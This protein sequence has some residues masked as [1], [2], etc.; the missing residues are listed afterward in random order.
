MKTE[1]SDSEVV[2]QGIYQELSEVKQQ[3]D[4]LDQKCLLLLALN[5]NLKSQA[6]QVECVLAE[7]SQVKH[8]ASQWRDMLSTRT[9]ELSELRGEVG[10]LRRE[11][12]TLKEEI[13][14][15]KAGVSLV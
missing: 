14:A 4:A 8:E 5:E 13:E 10:A 1:L 2:R 7:I 3:R 6:S 12:D 15:Q 9:A 11:N